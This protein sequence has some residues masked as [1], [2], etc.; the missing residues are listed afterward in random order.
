MTKQ[1]VRTRVLS[2][3]AAVALLGNVGAAQADTL[4]D[5][6]QTGIETHKL[7]QASQQ[8]IDKLV[9]EKNDLV[10]K[11]KTVLKEIDGL[12]VYN[13]QLSKQISNQQKEM[14]EIA[15]SIERVTEVERQIT[16]LMMR[17]VDSLERFIELDIP[18]QLQVRRD[19]I[20]RLRDLMDRSDVATSEKFRNVL[21]AY[22]IETAYGRTFEAY[23]GTIEVDGQ[24]QNVDF[25]Q[26]GRIALLYLS[27]DGSVAGA[28]NQTTR[29]WELLPDRYA[30]SIAQG[31][32]VARKQAAADQLLTLP[33]PAPEEVQ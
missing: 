9:D 12:K 30:S 5:I 22:Q 1:R 6:L 32:R 25:L 13:Q 2:A 16:P 10:Q 29:R 27:R 8:R 7:A 33:I 28:W 23:E 31:L 18:F 3:V 19:G 26:V 14:T 11:Y 24:Q 21:D 4:E 15:G 20:K 17:M